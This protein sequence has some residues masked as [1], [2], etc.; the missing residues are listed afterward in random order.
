MRDGGCIG[1]GHASGARK[2]QQ[3]K[4]ACLLPVCSL[5]HSAGARARAWFRFPNNHNA[6]RKTKPQLRFLSSVPYRTPS[7]S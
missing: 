5:T 1:H 2:H 7:H 6:G 3:Q 4:N